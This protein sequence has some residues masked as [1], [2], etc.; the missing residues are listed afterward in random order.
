MAALRKEAQ[1]R[2]CQIRYPG[3]CN[4]NSQTT[5]LAHFR[6]IGISGMGIKPP[7]WCGSW[8]C[9]ACHA[10]VD[11]CKDDDIQVA[12]AHGV[13]RTLSVLFDEGKLK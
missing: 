11:S 9:S 3:V 12:F 2:D 4:F 7:D 13:L 6:L 1:G 5:V 8:A 10:L